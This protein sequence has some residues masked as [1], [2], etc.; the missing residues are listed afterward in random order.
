MQIT[1]PFLSLKRYQ[2]KESIRVNVGVR[3]KDA[4]AA[5]LQTYR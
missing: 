1:L 3:I 5:F 4:L 2:K